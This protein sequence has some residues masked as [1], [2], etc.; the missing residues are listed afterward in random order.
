MIAVDD[1]RS[2]AALIELSNAEPEALLVLKQVVG[3]LELLPPSERRE[4]V[5]SI[6]LP[7]DYS[8]LMT[9]RPRAAVHSVWA[10][11]R[12][13][14]SESSRKWSGLEASD[15]Y[16]ET[17][18]D[19]VDSWQM[20]VSA[21]LY[22]CTAPRAVEPSMCNR[23]RMLISNGAIADGSLIG[24]GWLSMSPPA[25]ANLPGRVLSN[26]LV[27]YRS[28]VSEDA[29]RVIQLF[30][31][32][33]AGM[34]ASAHANLAQLGTDLRRQRSMAAMTTMLQL[35]ALDASARL[36]ERE[37]L[38][39]EE[40]AADVVDELL[41]RDAKTQRQVERQVEVQ[42]GQ[43]RLVAERKA[44]AIQTRASSTF[45]L[46]LIPEA[47]TGPEGNIERA[48][49]EHYMAGDTRW[50][51]RQLVRGEVELG[52]AWRATPARLAL[53]EELGSM[54]VPVLQFSKPRWNSA[55]EKF[56]VIASVESEPGL[57][58]TAV[59]FERRVDGRLI[60]DGVR[61]E[62]EHGDLA[63]R[64]S[65]AMKI[66][67]SADIE[68]SAR[69]MWAR[70]GF[71]AVGQAAGTARVTMPK[72]PSDPQAAFSRLIGGDKDGGA[73][74]AALVRQT[75]RRFIR[76]V[77]FLIL[78]VGSGFAINRW[79]LPAVTSLFDGDAEVNGQL[80]DLARS[81][82]AAEKVAT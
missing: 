9:E 42:S 43:D 61:L 72:Q 73:A 76:S 81:D 74:E 7:V 27:E 19:V 54:G 53:E 68:V 63:E 58:P 29:S 16:L 36:F 52:D 57:L 32:S 6:A 37:L 15:L 69:W 56:A 22:P 47:E 60:V 41:I 23:P 33:L 40:A 46:D 25:D 49:D 38:A 13:P 1:L 44:R 17:L 3:A 70:G 48:L 62:S 14:L 79:V 55:L 10:D 66:A 82:V 50:V 11:R 77:F 18:I 51:V 67:P 35:R 78:A 34:A 4:V 26:I 24:L 12:S 8:E 20:L 5:R 80:F 64:A 21:G 65:I 31:D 75:R 59:Q 39:H 30:N 71:E 45:F 28:V 2:G